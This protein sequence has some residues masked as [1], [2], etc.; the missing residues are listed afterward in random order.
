MYG[1]AYGLDNN[2]SSGIAFNP[3]VNGVSNPK[4]DYYNE[5]SGY[6]SA[7]LNYQNKMHDA[8]VDIIY[9]INNIKFHQEKPFF[10]PYLFFGL[11]A[12]T[13]NVMAD[14]LDANGNPYDY[15]SI[16][17]GN[18]RQQRSLVRGILDRDY[19][20]QEKTAMAISDLMINQL[21]LLFQV[22]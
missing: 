5:A 13:Y 3:A 10:A 18:T 11:G 22:V 2:P 15:E 8:G 4:A 9:N 14:Q 21:T 12:M 19:E 20:T 16:T 17:T 7:F 6:G 1:A